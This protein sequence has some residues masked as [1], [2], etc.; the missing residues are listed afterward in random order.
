LPAL[1]I[2]V[3]GSDLRRQSTEQTAA[4]DHPLKRQARVL[5]VQ[6]QTEIGRQQEP[7]RHFFFLSE[8]GQLFGQGLQNL[9]FEAQLEELLLVG[10]ADDFDL[11]KL[12][13]TESLEHPPGVRH[14]RVAGGGW[15]VRCSI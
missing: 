8:G 1:R 15:T 3:L 14:A 5:R 11:I 9:L 12:S 6:L 7:Q 2:H 13:T 4:A 10:L